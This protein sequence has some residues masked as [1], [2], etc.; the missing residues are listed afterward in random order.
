[1]H[2]PY[3]AQVHP[4]ADSKPSQAKPHGGECVM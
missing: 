3:S 4:F 2:Y 1:M